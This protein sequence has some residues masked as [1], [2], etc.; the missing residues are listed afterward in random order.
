MTRRA[1]IIG[2]PVGHSLSPIFQ[3]AAF[4][5][6]GLDVVYERWETP[7][8]DLPAR[9]AALR[10]PDVLGANVTVP[11]KEHVI[12]LLDEVGGLA[13]RAGAVN[14]IVNRDGRLFGF[15]TDGPGFVAA[16]R[17]E[18]FF[19]PAGR[20]FLL[21]GAGGAARGIALALLEARAAAVDIWNRTPERA[22]ALARDLG[23]PARALADLP[24]LAG[25]DCLVNCTTVGMK[26][27]PAPEG[28]P[29][30]L[31]S[32]GPGLLV[33]DIVYAPRVTPLLR[34]AAARGLR[35]LGGLPM[36]IYQGA[37]AFELWTGL[38][39]PVDVMVRAAENEL[40]RREGAGR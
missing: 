35:T 36:L 20:S 11:H 18:A 17:Q 5:H 10:A 3:Q 27:G 32:A 31:D 14:T 25:Y 6:S 40:A 21:L 4:A 12:P 7:L 33:V 34:E 38:P 30:P 28:L 37:L 23:A 16:L 24:Q 15:N 39:A 26:G 9:V 8:P 2:Y 29:C 19:E 13:A 1:G 22:A